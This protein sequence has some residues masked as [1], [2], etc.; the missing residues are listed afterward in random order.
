M[1]LLRLASGETFTHK[2]THTPTQPEQAECCSRRRRRFLMMRSLLQSIRNGTDTQDDVL[3][4]VPAA[5]FT[6]STPLV[7]SC[8]SRDGR[9]LQSKC[10]TTLVAQNASL[11][12]E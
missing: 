4:R 11:F 1:R 3:G 5:C 10:G 6:I 7:T 2:H 8:T 12:R 9:T